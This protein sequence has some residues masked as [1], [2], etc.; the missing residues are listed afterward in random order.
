[1]NSTP[2][3]KGPIASAD[4]RLAHAHEDIKRADEQLERLSE[5][6]AKIERDAARPRSVSSRQR[7]SAGRPALG[8]LV[9][10]SLAACTIVAALVWQLLYGSETKLVVALW[11]PQVVSTPSVPPETPPFP[12]QP[13]SS[14]VQLTAAEAAAPAQAAPVAQTITAQTIAAPTASQDAAPT[15]PAA[16]PDQTPLLQTMARDLA[17]LERSIEQLKATQQQIASDNLKAIG[18]LKASQEEIKRVLARVSGQNPPTTSPPPARPAPT[19]HKPAR[20]PQARAR[21]RYLREWM[22]DDW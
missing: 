9:G 19:L 18:E 13:A 8:V 21:P 14:S 5:Q 12:A 3:P 15:A 2:T 16:L 10:L 17:N 20:K 6:L 7:S 11:A 4:E 22:D 1:M